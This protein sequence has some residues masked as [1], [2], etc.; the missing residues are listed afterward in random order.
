VKGREPRSKRGR[1]GRSPS[2]LGDC[3]RASSGT[4]G[5][6][7][8][9]L[10]AD[11]EEDSLP[12]SEPYSPARALRSQAHE[13]MPPPTATTTN[14]ANLIEIRSHASPPDSATTANPTT[15][16]SGGGINKKLAVR[17]MRAEQTFALPMEAKV[18]VPRDQFR[19]GA[20]L[21][22][23]LTSGK[24]SGLGCYN[25]NSNIQYKKYVLDLVLTR[26]AS[27]RRAGGA[28][29]RWRHR[30]APGPGR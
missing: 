22:P 12:G 27:P 4:N 6:N 7:R 13:Q 19:G 14:R 25:Q 29:H 30:S 10:G 18:P 23:G 11:D 24:W 16:R 3:V 26:V 9:G 20:G 21:P 1:R 15:R 5:L 28:R 2:K 17:A 8:I